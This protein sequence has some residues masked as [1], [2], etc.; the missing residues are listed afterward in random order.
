MAIDTTTG[1]EFTPKS[2]NGAAHSYDATLR[3]GERQTADVIR[4]ENQALYAVAAFA[5]TPVTVSSTA[6]ARL[7]GLICTVANTGGFTVYDNTA[8]S[9]TVL[10]TDTGM[11]LAEIVDFPRDIICTIGITV[12]HTTDGTI[13]VLYENAAAA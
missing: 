2:T 11:A 7:K 9:G 1:H 10:Y 8:A 13:V 4:M 5:G 12:S 3:A 6:G